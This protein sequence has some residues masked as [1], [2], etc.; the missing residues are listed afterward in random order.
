MFSYIDTDNYKHTDESKWQQVYETSDELTAIH[1]CENLKSISIPCQILKQSDSMRPFTFGGFA[2]VKIFV[3]AEYY[4][5]ALESIRIL[6][7]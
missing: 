1:L 7:K 6:M 2:V 5:S 3:P 4:S